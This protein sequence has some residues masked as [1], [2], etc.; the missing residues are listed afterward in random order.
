MSCLRKQSRRKAERYSEMATAGLRADCGK[1]AYG[2]A[3]CYECRGKNREQVRMA[4]EARWRNGECLRCGAK[5]EA[6]LGQYC[7]PCMAAVR[8]MRTAV[9]GNLRR[10]GGCVRCGSDVY[11]GSW[12]CAKCR[13]DEIKRGKGRVEQRM[14]QGLCVECGGTGRPG[15]WFCEQCQKEK[16]ARA[17]ARRRQRRHQSIACESVASLAQ[18]G[19]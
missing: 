13:A 11:P 8:K 3:R 19:R 4:R 16:T 2:F 18:V 15:K 7:V 5:I 12:R 1:R 6:D 9:R 17:S 10:R 14:A